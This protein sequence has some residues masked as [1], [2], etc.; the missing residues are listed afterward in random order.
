MSKGYFK[1]AVAVYAFTDKCVCVYLSIIF[2]LT[3]TAAARGK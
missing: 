3:T 1:R 2:V